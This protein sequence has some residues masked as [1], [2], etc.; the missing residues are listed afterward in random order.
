MARNQSEKGP[1]LLDSKSIEPAMWNG[2]SAQVHLYQ[3]PSGKFRVV[4]NRSSAERNPAWF[5]MDC[6]SLV[7]AEAHY[8]QH[9]DELFWST[10]GDEYVGNLPTP[11]HHAA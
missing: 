4:A 5:Y 11:L 6:D 9:Q 7:E 2:R 1:V 8:A 3:M 10:L